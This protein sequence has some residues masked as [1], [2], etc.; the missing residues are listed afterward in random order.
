MNNWANKRV[1]IA[2]D[3]RINFLFLQAALKRTQIQILWAQN[4]K[5]V[6]ELLHKEK[7]VDLVLMDLKMPIMD[8]LEATRQLK[9]NFPKLPV[10]AQTAYAHPEDMDAAKIA[11]CDDFLSKPIK[12]DVLLETI[13]SFLSKS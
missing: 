5:E 6:L 10:I 11:G 12:P 8:G 7:V 9:E 3:E 13:A 4:G 1:I 2:E